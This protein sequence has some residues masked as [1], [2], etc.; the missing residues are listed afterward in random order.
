MTKAR[1]YIMLAVML[2]SSGVLYSAVSAKEMRRYKSAM[3]EDVMLTP[4]DMK[5][6]PAP[7]ALPAGAQVAV[8]D[9]D[10]TKPGP[11]TMRLKMPADYRIPP[12]RHAS[13]E[14]VTVISGKFNVAKG[15]KDDPAVKGT[16]L[17]PGSYFMMSPKSAHY[18]WA[19]EETVVQLHGRGPWKINYINPDDDPRK[20]AK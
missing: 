10:P 17:P 13:P 7:D 2:L 12:H 19:R 4:D 5:W 6:G 3:A 8:L 1:V 20:K 14:H 15:E 16:E 9:G 11:Y 18:A